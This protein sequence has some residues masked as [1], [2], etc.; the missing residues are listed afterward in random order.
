MPKLRRPTHLLELSGS[1]RRHPERRHAREGEPQPNGDVGD[2]PAYFSAMQRASFIELR[3]MAPAGVL[4]LADSILLEL[5]AVLLARMRAE[6]DFP[7]A[8]IGRL[9]SVLARCG[10]TPADRSR[11]VASEAPSGPRPLDEFA[12]LRH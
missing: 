3:D 6:R 11:V 4:C 12:S 1:F 9:T 8:L 7:A 2:P 5:A 10:M